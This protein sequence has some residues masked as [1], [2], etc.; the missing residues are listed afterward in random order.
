MDRKEKH[1]FV[2][3]IYKNVDLENDKYFSFWKEHTFLHWDWWVSL[4]LVIIPWVIWWKL[5]NKD[6]T[7]RFMF[8]NFF[9]IIICSWLDFIGV[10]LGLWY[11]TGKVIPTIPS[12]LPWDF[13]LFPISM[14]LLMQFRP[15]I[16]PLTKAILYSAFVS[17]LAEPLFDLLGFY[18]MLKWEYIYSFPIYIIIYLC[19]DWISKRKSFG[20]IKE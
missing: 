2:G 20:T 1:A 16:S 3:E 17:F 14:T 19:S 8:A 6:T 12:Y 10:V 13:C 9:V 4:G 18:T 7:A 15:N 5:R 11:Y